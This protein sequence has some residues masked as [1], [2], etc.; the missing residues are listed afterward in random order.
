[1]IRHFSKII[2]EFCNHILFISRNHQCIRKNNPHD[3]AALETFFQDHC[4]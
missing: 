2:R 1:M 3:L 4:A